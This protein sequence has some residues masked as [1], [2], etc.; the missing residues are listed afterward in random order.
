VTVGLLVGGIVPVAVI[1]LMAAVGLHLRLLAVREI[2]ERPRS[3]VVATVLQIVLLPA[4]ALALVA[5]AAPPPVTA[6]VIVAIAV[7]PGGA[8]SN[9]F[10]HLAGGNLALSILMT[11]VTTLLVSASAPA[12]LAL[13]SA[14]GFL[15][16]RVTAML[17]PLAVAHDLARF[18]LL[19]LCA[20]V[21]CAHL[22]PQHL[23]RLRRLADRLGL[24]AIAVVLASSLIVSWPILLEAAGETLAYAAMFSLSSL[25]LGAAV[26]LLL[27]AGDRSACVIEFG[28]RNLSIAL[29]LATASTPSPEVVAFLLAYFILNTIV[30]LALSLVR[31]TVRSRIAV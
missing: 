20:G 3:L 7:S 14:S 4:V 1:V 12:M 29:V 21:L 16:A 26:S 31:R 8:L 27:P 23:P 11:M 2:I 5:L 19:P 30:L 17:D 9:A 13:A 6:L 18:A 28:V 24:L 25:A 22:L 10:T 15:D